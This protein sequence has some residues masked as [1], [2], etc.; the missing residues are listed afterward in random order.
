MLKIGTDLHFTV[1]LHI[2]NHIC[3][4]WCIWCILF[5]YIFLQI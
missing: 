5:S 1:T 4:V 2:C 3:T